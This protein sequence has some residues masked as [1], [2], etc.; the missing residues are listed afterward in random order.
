MKAVLAL[1]IFIA[2]VIGHLT[3]PS[4]HSLQSRLSF[5]LLMASL[6]IG[7]LRA[8][9]RWFDGWSRGQSTTNAQTAKNGEPRQKSKSFR[10]MQALARSRFSQTN[11]CPNFAC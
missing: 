9:H 6:I 1:R 4:E 10:L 7:T 11:A 5:A 3:A 2:A 8:N